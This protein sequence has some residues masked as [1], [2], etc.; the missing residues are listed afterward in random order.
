M[1]RFEVA[2]RQGIDVSPQYFLGFSQ[3]GTRIGLMSKDDPNESLTSVPRDA[4][5]ELLFQMLSMVPLYKNAEPGQIVT[6][7]FN[8]KIPA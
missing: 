6:L 1:K 8:L 4:S 3:D 2:G 5:A 7:L